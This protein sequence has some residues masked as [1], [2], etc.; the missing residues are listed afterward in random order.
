MTLWRTEIFD[1]VITA[2][3]LVTG[4]PGSPP[5]EPPLLPPDVYCTLLT[6]HTADAI[7]QALRHHLVTDT[8]MVRAAAVAG[9]VYSH[10]VVYRGLT[11][12]GVLVQ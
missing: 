2:S 7:L 12:T 6:V 5:E 4:C 1:F 11:I 8:V 9:R 3:T 10:F